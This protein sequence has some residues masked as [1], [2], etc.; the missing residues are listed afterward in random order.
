MLLTMVDVVSC[1]NPRCREFAQCMPRPREMRAYYCPI[2]GSISFAR[3]VDADLAD[4]PERLAAY[5]RELNASE[6]EPLP[7]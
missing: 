5:L 6:R 3:V 7:V 1:E 2:C 4:S